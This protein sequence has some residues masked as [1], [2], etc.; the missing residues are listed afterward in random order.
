MYI[1]FDH[2]LKE[3]M[4]GSPL[5]SIW[6]EFWRRTVSSLLAFCWPFSRER[7]R[8]VVRERKQSKA[9][10]IWPLLIS[11]IAVGS[12]FLHKLESCNSFNLSVCVCYSYWGFGIQQQNGLWQSERQ[13]Q[14]GVEEGWERWLL[15]EKKTGERV[16][17]RKMKAT[18]EERWKQTD[19]RLKAIIWNTL[20][21]VAMCAHFPN[22][23]SLEALVSHQ[24]YQ[25]YSL[26]SP[27]SPT[28]PWTSWISEDKNATTNWSEGRLTRKLGL[29]PPVNWVA[30]INCAPRAAALQLL[31]SL[32]SQR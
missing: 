9:K 25:W 8:E 32:S 28:V 1:R 3:W 12:T 16:R 5:F 26:P 20:K 22:L 19:K 21:C 18:R 6:L 13:E 14:S 31:I 29:P 15:E 24:F 27:S 2:L 10:L 23:S 11:P 7:D 4:H 30:K 17:N